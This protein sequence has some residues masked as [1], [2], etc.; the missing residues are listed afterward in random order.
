MIEEEQDTAIYKSDTCYRCGGQMALFTLKDVWK[1]RIDGDL[2]SV[3]VFAI[4]CRKCLSCG[5]VILDGTSDEPV[6]WCRN[7]Y[8]TERG[9]N[10]W[11]H[12]LRR[13]IRRRILRYRDRWNYFVYR[14]FCAKQN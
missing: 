7:K 13:S 1:M 12:K 4:P 8:L 14:M 9:L 2:H 11:R 10:T 5:T 6:E 3:P